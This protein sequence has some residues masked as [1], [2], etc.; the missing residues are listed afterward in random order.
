MSGKMSVTLEDTQYSTRSAGG[1]ASCAYD[2]LSSNDIDDIVRFMRNVMA[3]EA[4][5]H[6][7]RSSSVYFHWSK[8]LPAQTEMVEDAKTDLEG[9]KD[10]TP[11]QF[12]VEDQALTNT[13]SLGAYSHNPRR[14]GRDMCPCRK[15]SL[16]VE[17]EI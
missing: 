17:E 5:E 4:R 12:K 8:T 10:R 11:N 2:V 7:F 16:I 3:P 15:E 13:G 9:A 14:E 1:D 6:R